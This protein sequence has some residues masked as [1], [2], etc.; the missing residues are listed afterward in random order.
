MKENLNMGVKYSTA[1]F[2]KFSTAI[3]IMVVRSITV[4]ERISKA[5][6]GV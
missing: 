1:D 4:R 2:G 6:Q 5:L 3:D